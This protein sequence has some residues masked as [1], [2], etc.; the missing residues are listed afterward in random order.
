MVSWETF[1]GRG[2]CIGEVTM[3]KRGEDGGRIYRT[4][5]PVGCRDERKRRD[6]DRV[7]GFFKP[8]P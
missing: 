5:T 7:S 4:H 3:A 1:Q 6:D 2:V 8:L